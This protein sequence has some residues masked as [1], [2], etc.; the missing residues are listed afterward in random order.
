MHNRGERAK[1][2]R[3]KRTG[4]SILENCSVSGGARNQPLS[5]RGG[6]L[7]RFG[8]RAT[9]HATSLR[10]TTGGQKLREASEEQGGTQPVFESN[11]ISELLRE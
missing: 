2:I 7:K 11:G 6:K 4:K 8:E 1:I 3:L 9:R 5:Q 10:T